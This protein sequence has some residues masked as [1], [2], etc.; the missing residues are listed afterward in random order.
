MQGKKEFNRV[1]VWYL[2]TGR[3]LSEAAE[4]KGIFK[5]LMG[6]LIFFD[7]FIAGDSLLLPI[8]KRISL[9]CKNK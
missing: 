4:T 7:I 3:Q 5:S 2:G 1:L 8:Y 6:S 9:H